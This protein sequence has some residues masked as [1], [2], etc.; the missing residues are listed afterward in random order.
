MDFY[1]VIYLYDKFLTKCWPEKSGPILLL[2]TITRE[3]SRFINI[4]WGRKNPYKREIL[5]IFWGVLHYLSFLLFCT[6]FIFCLTVQKYDF[7]F[8]LYIFYLISTLMLYYSVR[9]LMGFWKRMWSHKLQIIIRAK[10]PYI[11]FKFW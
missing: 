6:V 10:S 4:K 7:H 8:A 1:E 3:N 11:K 2:I 5:F 9:I